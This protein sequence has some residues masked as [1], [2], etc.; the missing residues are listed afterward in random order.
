MVCS[1]SSVG[2]SFLRSFRAS[3]M[4][5]GELRR[6]VIDCY[7]CSC[8]SFENRGQPTSVLADFEVEQLRK[9]RHCSQAR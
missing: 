6:R 7:S 3:W 9:R 1:Y 8:M 5:C 4:L 2:P